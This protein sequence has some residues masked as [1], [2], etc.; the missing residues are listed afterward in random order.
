MANKNYVNGRAYEYKVKKYFEGMGYLM[1]RSAGSKS[2]IDLIGLNRKKGVLIVLQC[3]HGKLS[4]NTR[5]KLQR[6]LE[7]AAGEPEVS[8]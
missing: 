4:G 8:E 6:E 7:E 2:P 1:V 5:I 3:K